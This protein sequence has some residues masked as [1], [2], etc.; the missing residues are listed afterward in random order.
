[1]KITIGGNIGCGKT[2]LIRALESQ[3]MNV[4][5][6]PIEKWGSW[7]DLFYSDMKRFC[8]S[9]QM[10]ILYDFLDYGDSFFV[11]ERSP[12]DS[13]YVFAK[14]LVHTDVM[15]YMEYNLLSD[16]VGRIGWVPDVYIYLRA[17]PETCFERIQKRS[18][19]CEN[20]VGIDYI[21]TIHQEYERL[22][23]DILPE[24][25]VQVHVLDA[26]KGPEEVK[27]A[28]ENI[29]YTYTNRDE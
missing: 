5:P 11:S 21:R 20:G 9:F 10:K 3:G 4:K 12:M 1:M 15:S 25:N 7:L 17:S 24:K 8:F 22:T 14:G 2:T 23:S 29:I 16:F 19:D 28:V 6:E 26:S 13:L 18:R 27:A